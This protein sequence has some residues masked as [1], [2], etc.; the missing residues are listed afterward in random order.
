[1]KQLK[2]HEG[3]NL[4][5]W[6]AKSRIHVSNVKKQLSYIISVTKIYYENNLGIKTGTT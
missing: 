2:Y 3:S 5:E 4:N 1:M 6:V